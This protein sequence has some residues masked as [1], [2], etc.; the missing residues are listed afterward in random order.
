MPTQF[1]H[2]LRVNKQA[3]LEALQ[4]AQLTIYRHSERIADLAGKR[5]KPALE[6]AKKLG[7][8]AAKEKQA[9]TPTRLWAAFV[10]SGTGR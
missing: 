7:P 2:E 9:T 6:A 1:Y 5:G 3:P 4:A 8:A 10:L